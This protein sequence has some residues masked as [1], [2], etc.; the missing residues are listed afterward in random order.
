MDESCRVAMR[1]DPYG[2]TAVLSLVCVVSVG[3]VCSKFVFAFK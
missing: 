2:S 1:V 3:R